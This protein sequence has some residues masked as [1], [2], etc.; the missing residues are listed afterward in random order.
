MKR[1]G[2]SIHVLY[3]LGNN[4]HILRR[5][6]SNGRF[7][8][9]RGLRAFAYSSDQL[10]GGGT[11]KAPH[12]RF[13]SDSMLPHVLD[14]TCIFDPS[15]LTFTHQPSSLCFAETAFRS[16]IRILNTVPDLLTSFKWL[17]GH[18]SIT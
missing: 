6:M 13:Q 1:F 9:P 14:G 18:H 10:A 2:F 11:L 5:Q 7:S 12:L 8:A 16:Y 3:L 4:P 17:I 15:I